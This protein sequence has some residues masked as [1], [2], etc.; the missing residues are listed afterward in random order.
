MTEEELLKQ[1]KK[2][3]AEQKYAASAEFYRSLAPETWKLSSELLKHDLMIVSQ[4]QK[5][6]PDELYRFAALFFQRKDKGCVVLIREI[7][8]R[9]PNHPSAGELYEKI[10]T[11]TQPKP[12]VNQAALKATHDQSAAGH[13]AIQPDTRRAAPIPKT[14]KLILPASA[15]TQGPQTP[16]RS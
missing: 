7:L 8:R 10:K 13:P 4:A 16:H 15:M 5:I 1:A 12:S 9:D 3:F 14:D 6:T 2:F 11:A